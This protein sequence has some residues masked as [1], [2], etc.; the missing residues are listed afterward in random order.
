MSM[1][2][3]LGKA[4]LL[5]A[6]LLPVQAVAGPRPGIEV[7]IQHA[8]QDTDDVWDPVGFPVSGSLT[9]TLAWPLGSR[10]RLTTGVGYEER[11]TDSRLT[12]TFV[13]L[14]LEADD[15]LRARS[16]LLPLRLATPLGSLLEFEAGPEWR[17]M[18]QTRRRVSGSVD[19]NEVPT[20]PWTDV[21]SDWERSS[22]ALAAGLAAHW[23]VS[24]GEARVGFRWCEALGGQNVDEFFD[25]EYRFRAWQVTLAWSR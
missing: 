5:A 3:R 11:W 22:F 12:L 14:T 23:A 17:W 10:L 6:G 24:G 25:F 15:E 18:L 20:T 21:T 4:L 2:R 1:S 7:A 19:G 8:T 13:G 9:G 16:L